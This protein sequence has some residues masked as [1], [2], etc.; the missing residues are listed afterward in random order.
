MPEAEILSAIN[1]TYDNLDRLTKKDV[2]FSTL[3]DVYEEYSYKTYTSGGT[4]YTTPL[5]STLTFKKDSTTTATY[6]YTYDSLG[7]ITTISK[8]G[9]KIAE[10]EYDS[11]GQLI[12]EDDFR[13]NILLSE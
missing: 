6:S 7:N 4:Q 5:V 12:R 10:Y 8:D 13:M 9:T 11:L 1:Y 3:H 2:S